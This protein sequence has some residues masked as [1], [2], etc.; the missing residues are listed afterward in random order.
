M[1]SQGIISLVSASFLFVPS[2][3]AT[4]SVTQSQFSLPVPALNI[5]ALTSKLLQG[6]I[7]EPEVYTRAVTILESMEA[8]PS[9]HRIATLTLINSCQSLE[10][11]S[12]AEVELTEIREEYA[13][14]LA[15]CELMGAKVTVPSQCDRFVPQDGGCKRKRTF[16]FLDKLRS[17]EA[18]DSINK[19]C[20][21]EVSPC[22][23]QK[24]SRCSPRAS[25]MVD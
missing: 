3:S 4:V 9:C 19:T 25:T 14:R 20:Y 8:A 5:E 18:I 16:A 11:S 12:S 15:M 2:V 10:R 1:I 23:S 24:M 7:H 13:T 21:R 22:A 6:P 17:E